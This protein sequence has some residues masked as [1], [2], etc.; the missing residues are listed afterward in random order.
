MLG[1]LGDRPKNWGGW[2][3]GLVR[4]GWLWRDD[5]NSA[6]SVRFGCE[7]PAVELGWVHAVSDPDHPVQPG[8]VLLSRSDAVGALVRFWI[9]LVGVDLLVGRH[10]FGA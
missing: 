8:A 7:A 2:F 5:C 3:L 9:G 6:D 4:V 10:G 1:V